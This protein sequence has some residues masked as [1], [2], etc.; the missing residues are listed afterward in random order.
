MSSRRVATLLVVALVLT[1]GCSF[2]GGDTVAF[3]ASPASV[4]S[5]TLSAT[6]YST[7]VSRWENQSRNVTV[8]GQTR[9]LQLDSYVSG[10]DRTNASGQT[11]GGFAL[12]ATPKASVAGQAAN[13][14]GG[15]SA[16]DMVSTLSAELDQ[17]GELSDI[18][19]LGT[20][21]VR[22]LGSET[23]R[24]RFGATGTDD[25]GDPVDVELSILRVEHGS[26]FVVAGSIHEQSNPGER[27]RLDRLRGCIEHEDAQPTDAGPTATTTTGPDKKTPTDTET[28]VEAQLATGF[29]PP[30]VDGLLYG[31]SGQQLEEGSAAEWADGSVRSVTLRSADGERTLEGTLYVKEV[32]DRLYV[33]LSAPSVTESA[34]DRIAVQLDRDGDGELSAGDVRLL[35][36][37][38]DG[39][40]ARAEESGAGVRIEVFRDGEWMA[41]DSGAGAPVA[42][43]AA[44]SPAN[45][46]RAA[47]P[48]YVVETTGDVDSDTDAGLVLEA[49]L[50]RQHLE[51]VAGAVDAESERT[52][53]W[54]GL[55][56]EGETYGV[57]RIDLSD[58]LTGN[59]YLDYRV[60]PRLQLPEDEVGVDHIEVT[61]S[62]QTASNSLRLVRE[63]ESLARVFVT[64][65]NSDATEVTVRLTGYDVGGGTVRTLGTET[66]TFDAPS[67]TPDRNDGDDSANIELPASWTD[68]EDLRLEARVYRLGYL[69]QTPADNSQQTTVSFV[70]TFDPNIYYVRPDVQSGAGTSRT[71]TATA[72][73]ATASLADTYPVADPTFIE[74]AASNADFEGASTSERINE[75]NRVTFGLLWASAA[76]TGPNSPARPTQVYGFTPDFAGISDPAWDNGASYAS[77]GGPTGSAHRRMVMAHE[78]NHNL[79]DDDWGKH[80]GNRSANRFANGCTAGADDEWSSI[81]PTNTY[82]QEVGWD[83]SVGI[84]P[85][86]FPEFESYCQIW[87]VRSTVPGWSTNDPPQWISD[88]R[89][90]RLAD[91]FTS[92]DDNPAH[93]NLRSDGGSGS[94]ETAADSASGR[95]LLGR[96]RPTARLIS[97]VLFREGGGEL[98]PTFEQ[99]GRVGPEIPGTGVGVGAGVEDPHAVLVVQ[100]DDRSEREI[101]L[102][103]RFEDGLEEYGDEPARPFT[104]PVAD[105]GTVSSITLVDADTG[106]P[107]DRLAPTDFRLEEASFDLPERFG[108]DQPTPVAV[109]LAAEAEGPLY[110]Q[111]LYTPDGTTL[112][113]FSSV[114]TDGE[115]TAAFDGLPGGERARFVLLVSDGVDTRFV[116]S[117]PFTV[118]PAAPDVRIARNERYVVE[119]PAPEDEQRERRQLRDDGGS[120]DRA[121]EEVGDQD[122]TTRRV[123]GPVRAV[124]GESV[125][126]SAS[127][128]DEWGRSLPVSAVSWQATDENGRTVARQSG[129]PFTHRFARPGTYEVTVT[130][131]D[132]DTGLSDTDTIQVVVSAP[133]LP[134]AGQVDELNAAKEEA[135]DQG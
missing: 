47:G 119:G 31:H 9:T 96:E 18:Q 134:D 41:T 83:P 79:G 55:E 2:L 90:E 37:P 105:N 50:D 67:G 14:V 21:Q 51:E 49:A 118:E 78:I 17:Y 24:T 104:V 7:E 82:I 98:R 74:L 114:R 38:S 13:P 129:T 65:D 25:N 16:R 36:T 71:T 106:E 61:Q 59:G 97:G 11:R 99:P 4:C 73:A 124:A 113:P 66:T 28:P 126:L 133:P 108:R 112:Y 6:G 43:S 115:F 87:E 84:I 26:D 103:G 40:D 121:G 32:Q 35:R 68:V 127:T 34:P 53:V 72:D 91:R 100:Y 58:E 20:D 94:A 52:G 128:R 39:D 85:Q 19:R 45:T 12:F 130:G 54:V 102:A 3:T 30:Q 135:A 81:N 111:L 46:A 93:P 117:D 1:S 110:T 22:V 8:A 77:I 56:L 64:H 123:G 27:E 70:E 88:Y 109:D 15:M 29:H 92:W 101:P 122:L 23:T 76:T 125:S 86:Q 42:A 63:K 107:L 75:L 62:V 80:V 60:R 44:V 95:K 132:P 89:W 33:A 57:E 120:S 10:Y 131:T 69:D 48:G 116:T 5:D